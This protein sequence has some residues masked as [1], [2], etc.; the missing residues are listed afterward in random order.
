[1]SDIIGKKVEFRILERR[2]S[3][4]RAKEYIE[5]HMGKVKTVIGDTVI[6]EG[7]EEGVGGGLH[8]R[9]ISD[10]VVLDVGK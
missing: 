1:M 9:P 6:I 7:L 2:R 4:G 10:I 3:T 8:S 5:T